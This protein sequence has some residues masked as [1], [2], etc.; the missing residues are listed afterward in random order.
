MSSIHS[1][2]GRE[3]IK[4]GYSSYPFFLIGIAL[5]IHFSVVPFVLKSVD[6][7]GNIKDKFYS[8][9]EKIELIFRKIETN[10]DWYF[11]QH[12]LGD[13]KAYIFF[14]LLSLYLIVEFTSK[15]K[16]PF[17]KLYLDLNYN[18]TA[19]LAET[20]DIKY[21]KLHKD[22]GKGFLLGFLGKTGIYLKETLSVLMVAPPG[23]GKTQSLI[24]MIESGKK[25]SWVILDIKKELYEKTSKFQK[26]NSKIFLLE[27]SN[28]NSIGWNP[29]LNIPKENEGKERY[30]Q[31][32]AEILFQSKDEKNKFFTDS[33]KEIFINVSLAL[34]ELK[35][36]INIFEV[37]QSIEPDSESIKK[38][39]QEQ[40]EGQEEIHGGR[41]KLKDLANRLKKVK[42][43]S[44][45]YIE[46][47]QAGLY[48]MY[49]QDNETFSNILQTFSTRTNIFKSENIIKIMTQ[50]KSK[51]LDFNIIRGIDG[52]PVTLYVVIKQDEVDSLAIFIKLF[53]EMI[54]MY[55]LSQDSKAANK[56]Y[57]ITMGIDEFSRWGYLKTILNMP[58]L[59]R[60]QRIHPIIITQTINQLKDIYGQSGVDA[61]LGNT[62][63]LICYGSSED[64]LI[65][66]ISK[67]A[68]TYEVQEKKRNSYL[69]SANPTPPPVD[70]R[71]VPLINPQMVSSLPNDQVIILIQGFFRRPIVGTRLFIYSPRTG[72]TLPKFKKIM[73]EAKNYEVNINTD[74]K[75][76]DNQKSIDDETFAD[77]KKNLQKNNISKEIE[78][79]TRNIK[80]EEVDPSLDE[81]E[82]TETK[83]S[84]FFIETELSKMQ[85]KDYE[86]EDEDEDN[87]IIITLK[88]TK[89][90][91][92]KLEEEEEKEKNEQ[93]EIEAEKNKKLNSIDTADAAIKELMAIK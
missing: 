80:E 2:Q 46:K 19:L 68:G 21:M 41:Y 82:E 84:G 35:N 61:L 36:I 20:E 87:K 1:K 81:E 9:A 17:R 22:N 33:A 89:M 77:Y 63:A 5:Y 83:E 34:V 59:S 32:I 4:L 40:E 57:P 51:S 15:K 50:E 30:V 72:K 49:S 25:N 67:N 11:Y 48:K 14:I 90:K 13:E 71:A 75:N 12:L 62:F 91:K 39:K 85:N 92:K 55:F 78:K 7:T 23:T 47:I 52:R 93:I 16:N 6:F 65:D 74:Q 28:P 56:G 53:F 45:E 27:P 69:F 10:F 26:D 37:I 64:Y 18:T 31:K 42:E 43:K 60:S 58:Q 66:K 38:Q 79:I 76:I 88:K 73:G 8:Y 29:F 44:P 86:D 54:A 3:F 70:K 24:R